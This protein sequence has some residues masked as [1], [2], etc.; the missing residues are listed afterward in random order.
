[1]LVF[2][3]RP[4]LPDENGLLDASRHGR[5]PCWRIIQESEKD[6]TG[7]QKLWCWCGSWFW[8]QWPLRTS[9]IFCI[10]GIIFTREILCPFG[11]GEI[12]LNTLACTIE[13][14]LWVD[15]PEHKLI[16]LAAV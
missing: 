16:S 4:L 13:P 7:L 5:P 3:L 8:L 10:S 11:V 14:R 12:A 9:G 2:H 15:I 6:Q 1:M